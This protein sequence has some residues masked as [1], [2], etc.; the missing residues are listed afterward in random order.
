[1]FDNQTFQQS[2]LVG[3]DGNL[4]KTRYK[5]QTAESIKADYSEEE[6]CLILL[7]WNLCSEDIMLKERPVPLI[8]ITLI[9]PEFTVVYA[10]PKDKKL[11]AAY[12]RDSAWVEA[13]KPVV[14]CVGM[15]PM[16]EVMIKKYNHLALILE[17]RLDY[18]VAERVDPTRHNHWTLRFTRD[19]LLLCLRQCALLVI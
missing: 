6:P 4:N 8:D 12:L 10:G 14:K 11:P 19:S 15:V 18:H 13:L 3:S 5:G 16:D 2:K 9:M 7:A 1:M 17:S